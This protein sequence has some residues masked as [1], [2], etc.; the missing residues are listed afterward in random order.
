MHF[1]I[2]ANMPKSAEGVIRRYGHDAVDV[3]NIGL[4]SAED[5]RIA[6]YA[7]QHSLAI[8]TRDFDFANIRNYP[9]AHYSGIVVL[10]LPDDAIVSVVIKVLESFLSRSEIVSKLPGRLAVVDSGRVRIRE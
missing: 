5:S 6:A 1:L 2:D 7:R 4:A 8:V 3:R 9:P 10:E